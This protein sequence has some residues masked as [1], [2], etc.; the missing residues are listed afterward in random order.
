MIVDRRGNVAHMYC[1]RPRK[2]ARVRR[3]SVAVADGP[4]ACAPKQYIVARMKGMDDGVWLIVGIR[5]HSLSGTRGGVSVESKCAGDN[6]NWRR[7]TRR[8]VICHG[9]GS[10]AGRRSGRQDGV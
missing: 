8:I 5:R 9:Y 10:C 1:D 2:I 4:K 7:G 6:L 3:H